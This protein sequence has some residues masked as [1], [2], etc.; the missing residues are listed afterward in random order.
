MVNSEL[1]IQLY[2]DP[3]KKAEKDISHFYL[4]GRG[5][6]TVGRGHCLTKD[7]LPSDSTLKPLLPYFSRPD[8]SKCVDV[9]ELR[10]DCELVRTAPT[11]MGYRHYSA[12]YYKPYTRL[13]FRGSEELWQKDVRSKINTL[14]R[15][16]SYFRDAA[17]S[18]HAQ[19]V[20]LDIAFNSGEDYLADQP[21]GK[22]TFKN[23][24][25][26]HIR[27]AMRAGNLLE[28]QKTIEHLNQVL[29][30]PSDRARWRSQQLD[31]AIKA[32]GFVL[33]A[34][35][36]PSA[37][38]ADAVQLIKTKHNPIHHRHSHK[39]PVPYAIS[40]S[41]ITM[42][43]PYPLGLHDPQQCLLPTQPHEE[44]AEDPYNPS[45]IQ[46]SV[47]NITT[48]FSHDP[49]AKQFAITSL[50]GK[51]ELS[52]PFRYVATTYSRNTQVSGKDLIGKPVTV[53]INQQDVETGKT[54]SRYINGVVHRMVGTA[55]RNGWRQYTLEIVPTLSLLGWTADVCSFQNK[56]VIEIIKELAQKFSL[57][58]DA[59]RIQSPPPER[60][61]CVQ[62]NESALNFIHRLLESEGI[63]YYF[64]HKA[65]SHVMTLGDYVGA[66]QS[67][68]K[69][70]YQVNNKGWSYSTLGDWVRKSTPHSNKVVTKDYDFTKPDTTL[71][72]EKTTSK[73]TTSIQNSEQFIFPGRF[74]TSEKGQRLTNI[75]ME[76][77]Q[78]W[79]QEITSFGGSSQL[80]PGQV[81]TL[82]DHNDAKQVGDY[83][84]TRVWHY[85]QDSAPVQHTASD[86]TYYHNSFSALPANVVARPQLT[87]SKPIASVQSAKVVGDGQSDQEIFVDQYGRACI[88]F[89]WARNNER[90]SWVRV[91][92]RWAGNQYGVIFHPRLGHEVLVDFDHGD[93]DCPTLIGSLYNTTNM[94]P[95]GLPTNTNRS[96]IKTHSL[97]GS[98]DDFNELYFDDKKGQETINW[99]ANHDFMQIT[100]Q[101]DNT[102]IVSGN[103][104]TQI[105]Q[106]SSTWQAEKSIVFN[107]G[108]AKLEVTQVGIFINGQQIVLSQQRESFDEQVLAKNQ[109]TGQ[110]VPD[111]P[112]YIETG[113]GNVFSGYTDES[114]Q[115]PRIDSDKE[116]GEYHVYWGDEALA[117]Q[118]GE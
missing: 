61:Y 7:Q 85:A 53:T 12:S 5:N 28:L 32:K 65:D 69:P 8:G 27:N 16:C 62:Y 9:D 74:K 58:V 100:E 48:P 82:A 102:T 113:D 110:H 31:L 34:N 112:F 73:S 26:Q 93:P 43:S 30:V 60:D 42:Q 97:N 20:L 10:K 105:L 76:V 95:Y 59:R 14:N 118:Q 96:G 17:T 94:P 23:P 78:A 18:T 107:V 70:Q 45:A 116:A 103:Q 49:S 38:G 3:C 68:N 35:P 77:E 88:Q 57:R 44:I 75:K 56:N 90:T 106:G 115:L 40:A 109:A 50:F 83:V 104:L 80:Q 24:N 13:E 25:F 55:P 51:E 114:G 81:F 19:V 86:E 84:V 71:Q 98:K 111:H 2:R 4:D 54:T 92:Q 29:G 33:P 21:V 108:A 99:R 11:G 67:D 101:N 41:R 15:T 46:Q 6:L 117:K 22:N 37:R 63:F 89:P 39:Q 64:V 72:A 66:Y 79:S 91:A 1:L 47:L 87:T 52:Q 36:V